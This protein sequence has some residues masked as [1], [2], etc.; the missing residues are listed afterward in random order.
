MVDRPNLQFVLYFA[1][2]LEDIRLMKYLLSF[3]LLHLRNTEISEFPLFV[4]I[5]ILHPFLFS[6]GFYNR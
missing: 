3:L 1:I 6:S 2:K 5:E 4:I